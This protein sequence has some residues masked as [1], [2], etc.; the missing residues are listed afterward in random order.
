MFRRR[1]RPRGLE[2][3]ACRRCNKT[4]AA[5]EQ[6]AAL[7]ARSYPDPVSV[8]EVREIRAYLRAVHKQMPLLLTEMMPSWRQTYDMLAQ[9]GSD[10]RGGVLNVGGPL[11]NSSMRI[12]GAKLAIALHYECTGKILPSTG[13]VYVHWYTNWNQLNQT[14]PAQLFSSLGAP[15][16]LR[17]GRWAV[18]EQ[19]QYAWAAHNEG[20]FGLYVS[21]F[22]QSFVVAGMV[23]NDARYFTSRKSDAIVVSPGDWDL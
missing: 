19:F 20:E 15:E 22:R 21:S 23:H 7:L 10:F 14:I 13:G 17:Q 6:V 12:F 1:A 11:V 2:F 3:P 9:L 5:H 4:T 8:D 16:T 18:P